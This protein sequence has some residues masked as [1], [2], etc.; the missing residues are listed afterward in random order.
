MSNLTVLLARFT[1]LHADHPELVSAELQK[2]MDRLERA[3]GQATKLLLTQATVLWDKGIGHKLRISSFDK[4]VASLPPVPVHYLVADPLLDLVCLADPRPGLLWSAAAAKIACGGV[5]SHFQNDD[6]VVQANER[7]N[8]GNQPFWFRAHDGKSNINCGW[9]NAS[10]VVDGSLLA[11]TVHVGLAIVL[12]HGTREHG[13]LLPGSLHRN[14]GPGTVNIQYSRL[15]ITRFEYR[16]EGLGY[17][18]V[19]FSQD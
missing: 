15:D 6:S 17:G 7:H 12:Q 16:D 4:Y 3:P 1:A 11:G 2:L 14:R 19:I 8:H 18:T 10:D 5:D 9:F 13:M